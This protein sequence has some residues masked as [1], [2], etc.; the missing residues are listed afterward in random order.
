MRPARHGFWFA[1][2]GQRDALQ[3]GVRV[4]KRSGLGSGS[5]E[6][7]KCIVAIGVRVGVGPS[8]GFSAMV[9]FDLQGL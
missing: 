2:Q 8:A 6:G 3:P 5:G 9:G 7:R 1:A 4:Q